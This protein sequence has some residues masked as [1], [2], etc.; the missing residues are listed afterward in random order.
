MRICVDRWGSTWL[1]ALIDSASSVN[2]GVLEQILLNQCL[3]VFDT[4]NI[5]ILFLLIIDIST[6][7]EGISVLLFLFSDHGCVICISLILF[8][9]ILEPSN[10]NFEEL[11]LPFSIKRLLMIKFFFFNFHLVLFFPWFNVFIQLFH[12]LLIVIGVF[13]HLVN[14][15]FKLADTQVFEVASLIF[16]I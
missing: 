5:E 10:G 7:Q 1:E 14:C 15:D 6:S 3:T 13:T 12:L 11:I 16:L 9:V 2:L 8:K 4:F